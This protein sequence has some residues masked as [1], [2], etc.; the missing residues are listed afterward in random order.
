MQRILLVA[1]AASYRIQAYVDAARA[2][3]VELV[4]A[5]NGQYSLIA[6]VSDGLTIPLDD[7][8]AAVGLATEFHAK[9]PVHAVVASDD[10]ICVKR[11]DSQYRLG[12]W[13]GS[14]SSGNSCTSTKGAHGAVSDTSP[15]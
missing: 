5:S 7:V 2:L 12:S 6:A 15:V 8:D 14:V 10:A 9:N 13:N 4:V 3:G 1:P 11:S